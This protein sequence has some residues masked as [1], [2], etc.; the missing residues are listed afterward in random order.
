MSCSARC[1]WSETVAVGSTRPAY[2][3][4]VAHDGVIC[5]LKTFDVAACAADVDAVGL[6]DEQAVSAP[7]AA[8]TRERYIQ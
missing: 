3:P 7:P 5:G 8:M 1:T 4:L 2:A 6:D